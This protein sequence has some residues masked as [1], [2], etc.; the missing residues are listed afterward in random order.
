MIYLEEYLRKEGKNILLRKANMDKIWYKGYIDAVFKAIF[1]DSKNEHLLKW[2]IE[3][4]LNQKIKIIK[5]I[6]PEIIKP[7]IYV[8][9]KTLDVLIEIDDEIVNVEVNSGYY[10]GLH[11]RNATYIFSK[12]SEEIKIGS[13]YDKMPKFYQINF[14][15]G[16]NKEYKALGIYK[17]TDIKTK[18]NYI[19]NLT[20]FEY[21]M[22]KIHDVCYNEG[23]MTYDYIAILDST[24]EELEK[25]CRGDKNMEEFK[26][27][28]KR[29]NED[30][31]YC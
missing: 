19:D 11:E 20:I 17:L 4:C 13:K 6:K 7:N 24:E 16:L 29:L 2:L 22:D 3:K 12:Y 15:R 21:N 5:I 18:I 23:D 31:R 1:C 25:I 10:T 27:N 26:D 9:N 8:K 30:R 14:T 28:I